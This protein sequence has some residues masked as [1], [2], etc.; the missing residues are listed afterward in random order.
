VRACSDH[1]CS[2]HLGVWVKCGQEKEVTDKCGVIALE[3]PPP[4]QRGPPASVG[5]VK[6]GGS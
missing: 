3:V 6:A 2:E 4:P 1:A 5:E